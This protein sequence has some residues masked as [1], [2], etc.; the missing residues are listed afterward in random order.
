MV[1]APHDGRPLSIRPPGRW[2]C[3]CSISTG[4]RPLGKIV[5]YSNLPKWHMDSG[6]PPS[7]AC[8]DTCRRIT[9]RLMAREAVA[10][11]FAL[12]ADS[13]KSPGFAGSPK[14]WTE[15]ETHVTPLTSINYLGINVCR[16]ATGWYRS[17]SV[18]NNAEV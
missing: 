4:R 7:T 5:R 10:V 8:R 13:P 12:F 9:I 1:V 6:V 3:Y 11:Q 18:A 17:A 2:Q 15:R 14:A 16:H